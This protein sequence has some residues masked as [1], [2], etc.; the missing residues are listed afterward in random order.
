LPRYA[1]V[2]KRTALLLPALILGCSR[3][4]QPHLS[5]PPAP[6]PPTGEIFVT[7]SNL[8]NAVIA[9]PPGASGNVSP[10]LHIGQVLTA[11]GVARDFSGRLYVTNDRL[12]TISIFAPG[13]DGDAPPIATIGGGNTRLDWPDAIALDA[14]GKIYVA[15]VTNVG[16]FDSI[17]VYAAGAHGNVAPIAT[18]SGAATRLYA[19][20]GIALDFSGKIYVTN[21]GGDSKSPPNVT[22]YPPNA[23]GDVAPISIIGGSRTGLITPSGIAVDA[24]GAIYVANSGRE[25]PSPGTVQVYAAGSNGN[26]AP[27]ATIRGAATHLHGP[28]AIAV[29]SSGRIYVANHYE[30]PPEYRGNVMIWDTVT[31]FAAHS[32]GD[33]A[34]IAEIS[35]PHTGLNGPDG[36][37]FDPNGN[38]YVAN[39]GWSVP[40]GATV[41]AY[42]ARSNGD[43]KPVATFKGG[44]DTGIERPGGIAFDAKGNI[45]VGNNPTSFSRLDMYPAGTDHNVPP[46]AVIRGVAGAITVD[47][48]GNIYA[49][50]PRGRIG[51]VGIAGQSPGSIT[52]YAVDTHGHL[53]PKAVIEGLATELAPRTIAVDAS[54]NIY[55]ANLA[56][57]LYAA[58]NARCLRPTVTVYRANSNG[59]TAPIATIT[60]RYAVSKGS[61]AWISVAL[62][63]RGR[64]YIANSVG[65]FLDSGSIDVYPALADLIAQPGYP[66]V[67]PIATIAGPH[68][69]LA[70]P[71]D[72]A[73]DP[74]GR[75]YVLSG[76]N[77]A[78]PEIARITVYPA[79]SDSRGDLDETPIT[80][81]EGPNTELDMGAGRIAVLD[82]RT[83][84]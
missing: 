80:T 35:G 10:S 17:N 12:R 33:V 20:S 24:S 11:S 63:S 30:E 41:T 51:P 76:N 82:R 40:F 81:I 44:T 28:T 66:D 68:T 14:S 32:R 36:V 45:Y 25:F 79:L 38:I 6:P 74:L 75:I 7:I 78:V 84:Q 70:R 49:A 60:S 43:V 50:D 77:D 56:C 57:G 23:D 27:I 64:I 16:S 9:F 55:S 29:D 34:P 21:G 5:P 59:N 37:A 46:A 65:G 73:L 72:I 4:S 53:T 69:M 39:D 48:K 26:A 15:N 61:P 18:I 1:F 13:G 67:K 42:P 71:L 2:W 22:V 31:V 83:M 52:V 3:I 19:P 58:Y 8:D 47:S 54:G 62:D